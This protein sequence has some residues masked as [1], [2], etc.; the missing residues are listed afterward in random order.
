M[1]FTDCKRSFI[2]KRP[3]PVRILTVEIAGIKVAVRFHN[4]I[5]PAY[6]AHGAVFRRAPEQ[7]ADIVV[8]VPDG[9][10]IPVPIV[11]IPQIK[12][13]FQK[14]PECFCGKRNTVALIDVRNK[15][16]II[17]A[18]LFKIVPRTYDVVCILIIDH[19][20]DIEIHLI[21]FQDCSRVQDLR[22]NTAAVPVSPVTVICFSVSVQRQADQKPGRWSAGR[23]APERK[24]PP[25]RGR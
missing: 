5:A 23:I 25:E 18:M 4:I 19:R 11:G 2:V 8:N 16:Q 20:K 15:L 22:Q 9:N 6:A 10:V 12:H 7:D 24:V 14:G 21:L 1:R 3:D 17:K 13:F